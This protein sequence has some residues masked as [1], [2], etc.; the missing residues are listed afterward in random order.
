MVSPPPA[1]QKPSL[2][3]TAKE[4]NHRRDARWHLDGGG[5]TTAAASARGLGVAVSGIPRNGDALFISTDVDLTTNIDV[6]LAKCTRLLSAPLR[7][8]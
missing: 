8:I 1:W 3:F 6:L 2:Q 4:A 7:S 5:C